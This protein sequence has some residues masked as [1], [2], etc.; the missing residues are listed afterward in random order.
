M[1]AL[2]LPVLAVAAMA[3]TAGAAQAAP[4]WF[5][6]EKEHGGSE[7]KFSDSE[8]QTSL[9]TGKWE[10]VKLTETHVRAVTFGE[11]TFKTGAI[12]ITCQVL[13]RGFIWNVT[14]NGLDSI[15]NLENYECASAQCA[16]SSLTASGFN[17]S[18]ELVA[19]T[20]P[21]D[22]ITG[23]AVTANCA[24]TIPP[25][26]NKGTLSPKIINGT[27]TEGTH[28]EFTTGTGEL[29]NSSGEKAQVTGK[30]YIVTSTGLDVKAE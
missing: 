26:F 24:G 17:W 7:P 19:G 1:Y 23:A 2:L 9:S 28:A 18:T 10:W 27:E 6:C 3:M 4:H 12:S 5:V 15:T 16:T 8:C 13:D 14:A 30:D 22:K 20:P 11:L 21:T 25:I 29:E